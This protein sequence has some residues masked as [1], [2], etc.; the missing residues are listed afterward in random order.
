M[1]YHDPRLPHSPS[2]CCS[3]IQQHRQHL[4][5]NIP[6]FLPC[7]HLNILWIIF[8]S[9]SALPTVLPAFEVFS[10]PLPLS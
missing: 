1:F 5:F 3:E 2:V 9:P 8:P 6:F 10:S 7:I 4:V